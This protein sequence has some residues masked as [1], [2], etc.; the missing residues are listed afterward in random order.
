MILAKKLLIDFV[1]LNV[2]INFIGRFKI[3]NYIIINNKYKKNI[4]IIK[5][6]YKFIYLVINIFVYIN[7]LILNKKYIIKNNHYFFSSF[8]EFII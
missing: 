5:N 3:E 6:T 4:F 2:I 8:E 1:Y 7:I